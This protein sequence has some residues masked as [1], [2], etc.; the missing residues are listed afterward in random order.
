MPRKPAQFRGVVDSCRFELLLGERSRRAQRSNP[1]A[2]D[3]FM[4][5]F[6]SGQILALASPVR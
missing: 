6:S 3:K 2:V 1:H 5:C 4:A